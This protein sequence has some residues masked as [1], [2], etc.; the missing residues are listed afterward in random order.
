MGL[1]R[2]EYVVETSPCFAKQI[3]HVNDYIMQNYFWRDKVKKLP[4]NDPLNTHIV[5]TKIASLQQG[6]RESD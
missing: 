3:E 4:S 6:Q 2:I 1:N 5:Q